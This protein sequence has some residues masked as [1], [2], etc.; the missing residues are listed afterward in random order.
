MNDYLKMEATK[1]VLSMEHLNTFDFY[2]LVNR[3][4]GEVL[5]GEEHRLDSMRIRRYP[6]K[7]TSGQL[8]GNY[9]VV[10]DGSIHKFYQDN[11][12]FK[13]FSFRDL[14]NAIMKLCERYQLNPFKCKIQNLE[15]GVN[16][17]LKTSPDR[18]FENLY[19]HGCKEFTPLPN[20]K[21]Y[22]FGI[23]ARKTESRLKMY[24][25]G[26]QYRTINAPPNL[27]RIEIHFKRSCTLL[28]IAE[29]QNLADL[30]NLIKTT[31]LSNYFTKSLE[32]A[33]FL[34][35]IVPNRLKSYHTQKLVKNWNN[36]NYIRQTKRANPKKY[37]RERAQLKT[38]HKENP[39]CESELFKRAIAQKVVK[40]L[41]VDYHTI[42]KINYFLESYKMVV[43]E[44]SHTAKEVTTRKN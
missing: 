2:S 31:R 24:A 40:M 5:E 15:I 43:F 20:S 12:N 37:R 17:L 38:I 42:C 23:E 26:V 13:D 14:F 33:V 28:R 10:V 39:Q 11:T 25:K 8:T 36:T 21:G 29:I 32:D 41:Q 34:N 22:S 7:D 30:L 1:A 4:T 9:T 3:K 6:K 27:V 18:F 44:R 19:S 35:Q 16:L